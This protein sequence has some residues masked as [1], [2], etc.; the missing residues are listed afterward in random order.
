MPGV[1][2]LTHETLR[3]LYWGRKLFPGV[4]SMSIME[5]KLA[6]VPDHK[7][8]YRLL[9]ENNVCLAVAFMDPFTNMPWFQPTDATDMPL[10]T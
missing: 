1:G 3:V 2:R 9:T 7:P 10:G 6:C 8:A 4:A 5:S